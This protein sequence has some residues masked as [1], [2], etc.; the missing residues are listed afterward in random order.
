MAENV[1]PKHRWVVYHF[2]ALFGEPKSHRF[3]FF[4]WLDGIARERDSDGMCIAELKDM[5][6]GE[7][8]T[9]WL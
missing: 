2:P 7:Y 5:K 4:A 8:F 6:T 9:D 3:Y 1:N